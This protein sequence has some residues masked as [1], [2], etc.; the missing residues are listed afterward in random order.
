LTLQEG[1]IDLENNVSIKF[2]ILKDVQ[3]VVNSKDVLENVDGGLA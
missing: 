3:V 2:T 1:K